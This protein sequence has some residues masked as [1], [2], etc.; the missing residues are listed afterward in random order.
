[1]KVNEKNFKSL[2]YLVNSYHALPISISEDTKKGVTMHFVY[3]NN[4]YNLCTL[5]KGVHLCN[6]TYNRCYSLLLLR[7]N[8]EL[9][10][11]SQIMNLCSLGRM[12]GIEHTFHLASLPNGTGISFMPNANML[13]IIEVY[14]R[15]GY[16]LTPTEDSPWPKAFK[17]NFILQNLNYY[18]QG[19]GYMWHVMM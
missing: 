12:R 18:N 16:N 6:E 19:H 14:R 11:E 2:V 4:I 8:N 13:D 7:L 3:D 17:Q 1:M 10:Y 9:P 15:M 5:D